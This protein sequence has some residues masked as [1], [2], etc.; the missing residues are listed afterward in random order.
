MMCRQEL[1][2]MSEESKNHLPDESPKEI[3]GAST[4]SKELQKL[5]SL[6]PELQ[7][8]R[9]EII[10]EQAEAGREKQQ[11]YSSLSTQENLSRFF[12]SLPHTPTGWMIRALSPENALLHVDTN[13]LET[14]QR[15][16]VVLDPFRISSL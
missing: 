1:F 6:R 4:V 7:Q 9:D 11:K 10:T 12:V 15:P 16:H 13:F 5:L 14:E 8:W 3:P 2:F